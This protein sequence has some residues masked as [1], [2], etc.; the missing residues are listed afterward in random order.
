[1]KTEYAIHPDFRR[2]RLAAPFSPWLLRLASGPQR[3]LL[4]LTPLPRGLGLRR[5]R[6]PG[7]RG[8]P[9]PLML[10]SPPDCPEK[11]PCLLYLHGGGFGFRAAPHHLRMAAQYALR[12]GCRVAF[13]DYHLLPKHPFPAAR[14]D[15]LAAYGYLV[16]EAEPLGID[17]GCL[18]VGG[19]SA[20]GTLAAYTALLAEA[21]GLPQ[22]RL[23]M[24]LY[25]AADERM[26][27]PSMRRYAGAPMWNAR[28]NAAMWR[29]L[30]RDWPPEAA[31]EAA[32]LRMPLPRRIPDAYMET[33]EIDCLHDEGQ[34][35]ARRLMDAGG[36]VELHDIR[37]AIHGYDM[38]YLSEITQSSLE[39]R[40]RALRSAFGK[41]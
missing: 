9:L 29:L 15:A 5:L 13:P 31:D 20:G 4:R 41:M 32:P 33:A 14:E 6:V 8:L 39:R 25:P 30:L 2:L 34:A 28:Q 17:G 11:A 3:L 10:L 24:M 26:Q 22:P 36:R 37:G 7:Y 1:M 35:L 21:R 12:A 38:V 23:C 19:D 16:A 27:F 40:V 18:A